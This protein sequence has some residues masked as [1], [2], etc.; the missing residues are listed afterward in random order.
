MF[1]SRLDYTIALLHLLETLPDYSGRAKDVQRLFLDLYRDEISPEDFEELSSGGYR[2]AKEVQWGRYNCVKKGLMDA[3]ATGVWRLTEAG[4][5][6]LEENKTS[7]VNAEN[8]GGP[9]MDHRV[10]HK[11]M[12]TYLDKETTQ[13]LITREEFKERLENV[14]SHQIFS[15]KDLSGFWEIIEKTLR[16]LLPNIFGTAEYNFRI[17]KSIFQIH[18]TGFAGCHYEIWLKRKW[19]EIG[20]HFESTPDRNHA[21]AR[22]FE[23]QLDRLSEEIGREVFA[24]NVGN[25]GWTHV[26]CILGRQI[27]DEKY[28]EDLALFFAYFI[29]VTLPTLISTYAEETT[30]QPNRKPRQ[31]AQKTDEYSHINMILIREVDTIRAL[32]DGRNINRPSDERLCDLIQFCYTFELYREG[33]ELLPMVSPSEVNPWYY[34]RTKKMVKVCKQRANLL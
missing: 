9:N 31:N 1:Q 29:M 11:L 34:E 17:R 5:R 24:E 18:I 4:R 8:I 23:I 28:A 3:P 30:R 14:K 25:R 33:A 16:D 22:N 32:I 15:I 2:W 21:R 20:L 13:R 12:V 6:W 27:F 10:E 7:N 19:D 26:Y